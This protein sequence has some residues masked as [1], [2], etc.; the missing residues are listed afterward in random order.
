M[1]LRDHRPKC[2]ILLFCNSIHSSSNSSSVSTRRQC[3]RR[4]IGRARMGMLH[5][6][7]SSIS[8]RSIRCR[9]ICRRTRH[10]YFGLRESP[11]NLRAR[12]C[13]CKA[14]SPNPRPKG[15]RQAFRTTSDGDSN[16]H[17]RCRPRWSGRANRTFLHRPGLA[18]TKPRRCRLGPQHSCVRLRYS[19]RA[20]PRCSMQARRARLVSLHNLPTGLARH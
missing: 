18:G 8:S 5:P 14:S 20:R 13:K 2:L 12:P 17:L 16:T 3:R 6:S 10:K 15:H 19:R 7:N 11:N 1:F 9:S 4:W